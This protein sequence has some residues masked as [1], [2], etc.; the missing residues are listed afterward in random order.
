MMSFLK[1]IV[2]SFLK[3]VFS[4][5]IYRL[6]LSG[7]YSTY[8][9]ALSH[10]SG[11]D[12]IAILNKVQNAIQ[13]LIDGKGTYERDGFLFN[14]IPADLQ[15]R[16]HLT[17]LIKTGDYIVDFGGGLGGT[18]LSIQ[19]ILPLPIYYNVIEQQHFV[20][21]GM[22]MFANYDFPL[23]FSTSFLHCPDN[24]KIVILSGVLQYI[25]NPYEVLESIVRL[26][27]EFILIDRTAFG[28]DHFWRLQL[29]RGV[30][31]VEVQYPHRCIAKMKVFNLLNE[32]RLI[33]TWSNGFDPIHPE[34][35]GLLFHYT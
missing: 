33:D 9:E 4:W 20:E 5:F 1:R 22:Q 11:Y 19:D 12:N 29:N 28:S 15:I 26:H 2:K 10:C 30:Y 34:H 6:P 18:Y 24:V 32:Y 14:S 17:R 7:H 16:K 13:G 23:Y 31:S 3:K 25:P 27:P 8:D 21:I 35:S